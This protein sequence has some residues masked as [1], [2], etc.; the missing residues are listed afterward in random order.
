MLQT[1][2]VMMTSS[3]LHLPL[4]VALAQASRLPTCTPRPPPNFLPSTPDCLSLAAAIG[5][6]AEMQGNVPQV[7]SQ[8]PVAPGQGRATPTC[9]RN[10]G[11]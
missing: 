3:F 10:G 9:F 8:Y 7:W 4:L 5:R 2:T 1:T 6:I 11:K